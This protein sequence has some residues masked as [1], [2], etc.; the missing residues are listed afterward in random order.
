[1]R[2][3]P[4]ILVVDDDPGIRE[5]VQD[6]LT[7][8]YRVNTASSVKEAEE[9]LRIQ[10]CD[11]VLTDMI[12]PEVGG[13][14]LLKYLRVHHADIPVI[15]F[16]GY[17]N[18]QD[19]VNAVKLGAFDYL[20]KPIQ[21]EIL[22]HA[23]ARALKFRL[24]SSQHTFPRPTAALAPIRATLDALLERTAWRDA[25]ASDM[26]L[27]LEEITDAPA[28]Q[29]TL[30]EEATSPRAALTA[31]SS[32]LAPRFGPQ[33]FQMAALVEPSHP[34]PERRACWQAFA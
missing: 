22:Q 32:Q 29:L 2:E 30:W 26:T 33:T 10:G 21:I 8:S 11:L 5:L 23:I 34:L 28:Q 3:T 18:F 15:V 9:Q 19:A 7:P 24:L 16:T 20:T 4:L 6:I 25:G 17:A 31:L 14:E 13:M 1:M 27:T 12:M